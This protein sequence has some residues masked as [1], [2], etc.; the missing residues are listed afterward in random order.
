MKIVNLMENTQ[1]D[2]GCIFQHGLSFYVETKKHKILVDAG[3]NGDI[4]ENAKALKVDLKKVDA[5]ILSHGHYDHGGG[6]LPFSELNPK[7]KIYLQQLAL[8]D[9]CAYDGAELGYRYIGID[10][11][12]AWLPNVVKL[13]GDFEIDEELSLFVMDQN[14]YPIPSTN[15]KI[16]ERFHGSYVRDEFRH[17]Q[18]LLI[19]SGKKSVVLSGCAH[20][21]I[22]NVMDTVVRKFGIEPDVVISGFHLMKKTDYVQE[23]LQE[24]DDIARQLQKYQKTTF[25]TCHCTGLPAFERMQKILGPNEEAGITEGRLFYVHCGET[26]KI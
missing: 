18:A 4:L 10:P 14:Q 11:R 9:Y 15:R 7:A 17:E 25:Y 6:I 23:E 2:P 1:G 24:I 12:I 3:P 20:N 16:L 8:K 22:L 5:M 13:E 26:I 19:R 21:G